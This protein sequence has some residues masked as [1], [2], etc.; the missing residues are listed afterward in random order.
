M[1]GNVW[2][3]H[4]LVA[5]RAHEY[6]LEREQLALKDWYEAER[7]LGFLRVAH[8]TIAYHAYKYWEDRKGVIGS[9]E[10]DWHRAKR[11]LINER[12]NAKSVAA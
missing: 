10:D 1:H 5:A 11:D 2:P 6:Y 4:D 8:V 3:P 7:G 12:F 9:A